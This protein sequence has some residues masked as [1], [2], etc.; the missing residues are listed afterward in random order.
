MIRD[1]ID[2]LFPPDK[3]KSLTLLAVG[4]ALVLLTVPVPWVW[5]G[6]IVW[7]VPMAGIVGYIRYVFLGRPRNMDVGSREK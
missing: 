1:V 4:I 2:A 3:S 7:L 5:V 6:N